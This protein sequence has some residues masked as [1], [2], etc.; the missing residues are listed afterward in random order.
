MPGG[1]ERPCIIKRAFS[2]HVFLLPPLNPFQFR[3][4]EPLKILENHRIS[5]LFR[6]YRIEETLA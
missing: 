1:K 4:Y 5:G 6:V 3:F 2:M